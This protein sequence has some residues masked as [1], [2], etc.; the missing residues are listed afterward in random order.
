MIRSQ[1]LTPAAIAFRRS[2][3]FDPGALGTKLRID[4]S[5]IGATE[6]T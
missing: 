5:E 6:R 3:D 2:V 4:S 1:R